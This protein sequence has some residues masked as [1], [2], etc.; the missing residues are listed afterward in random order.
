MAPKAKG[1]EGDQ[2]PALKKSR[3]QNRSQETVA[4]GEFVTFLTRMKQGQVKKRATDEDRK[5][6]EDTHEEYKSLAHQEKASFAMAYMENKNQKTFQWARD[7]LQTVR[8]SQEDEEEK[9]EKYMTRR[10]CLIFFLVS[11][12]LSQCV[13]CELGA[14]WA[15]TYNKSTCK[16]NGVRIIMRA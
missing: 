4:K 8:V 11:M 16:L 5:E 3:V 15:M 9:N 10:S 7:F 14:S 13:H 12:R 1:V 2:G 6:A